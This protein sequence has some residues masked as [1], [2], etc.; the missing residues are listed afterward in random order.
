MPYRNVTTEVVCQSSDN[1]KDNWCK[2]RFNFAK[3]FL[4]QGGKLDPTK[5]LDPPMPKTDDEGSKDVVGNSNRT[6]LVDEET[7]RDPAGNP[8][9]LGLIKVS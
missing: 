2:A 4:M 6:F 7:P 3:Q 8:T 1:P 9:P 5:T